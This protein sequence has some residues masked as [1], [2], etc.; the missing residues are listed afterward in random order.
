MPRIED[1]ILVY[2][3]RPLCHRA[4]DLLSKHLLMRLEY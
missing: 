4:C 1:S 2:R 3:I